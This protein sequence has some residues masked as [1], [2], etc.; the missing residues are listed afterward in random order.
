MNNE[1]LEMMKCR[2]LFALL[3]EF[4][5]RELSEEICREIQ[6]HLSDCD[7]CKAFLRTLQKTVEICQKLPSEPFPE[8]ARLELREILHTELADLKSKLS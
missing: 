1:D 8:E 6:A 7:P 3:S 4:I 5:D 2:Q